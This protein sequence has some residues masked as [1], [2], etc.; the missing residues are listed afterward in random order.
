MKIF[1]Y[2]FC[3]FFVWTS[4]VNAETMNAVYRAEGLK[5][6]LLSG[7]INMNL[8]KNDYHL[9]TSAVAKGLLA[10]F[11]HAQTVFETKGKIEGDTLT[12]LDSSMKMKDG[13][14]IETTRPN[15]ENKKGYLDYQS[16]L[17]HLMRQKEKKT[18]SVLVSDGKR[19]MEIRLLYGGEKELSSVYKGLSGT[20]ENW[21]VRI[22]ILSGKKKGWFFKRINEDTHSPLQLYFVSEGNHKSLML[23]TFDTGVVGKLYIVREKVTHE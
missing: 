9:E 1:F 16:L 6:P 19:D 15:F 5:I 23:G 11:I 10:A 12:V 17:L 22:K 18:H 13:K 20:A 4:P 8:T 7:Y 2:V 14:T 3:V 21:S